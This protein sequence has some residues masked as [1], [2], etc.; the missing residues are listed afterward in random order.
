MIFLNSYS[1]E[2]FRSYGSQQGIPLRKINFLFGP[3]SQGKSTALTALSIL[4]NSLMKRNFSFT[5]ISHIDNSPDV[6]LIDKLSN[7]RVDNEIITLSCEFQTT[8]YFGND[9]LL[10][11]AFDIADRLERKLKRFALYEEFEGKD[12][13]FFEIKDDLITI[14]FDS[15]Y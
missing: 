2:N 1:I 10:K 4:A 13:L 3:N 6:L 9:L 5:K 12:Q 14:N 8:D 7:N 15:Y 11:P